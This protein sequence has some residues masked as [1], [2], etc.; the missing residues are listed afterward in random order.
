[1]FGRRAECS[2]RHLT[3]NLVK[4]NS[5]SSNPLCT[6]DVN[7]PHAA[8]LFSVKQ[9]VEMFFFSDLEKKHHLF[10]GARLSTGFHPHGS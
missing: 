5:V 7:Y 3:S 8:V 1:M 6:R 10:V 9:S 2:A 4:L